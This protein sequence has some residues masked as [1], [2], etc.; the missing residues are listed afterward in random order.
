MEMVSFRRSEVSARDHPQAQ[1]TRTLSTV[2][3]KWQ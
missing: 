2:L 3:F 1:N